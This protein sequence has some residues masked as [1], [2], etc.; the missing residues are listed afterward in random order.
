GLGNNGQARFIFANSTTYAAVSQ[1]EPWHVTRRYRKNN[2]PN[3]NI[4]GT[5]CTNQRNPIID[6]NQTA[7]L[8]GDG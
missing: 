7:I 8:P 2:R 3:I 5:Y 6:G 4:E 1:T